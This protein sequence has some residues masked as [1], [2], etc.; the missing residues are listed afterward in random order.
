MRDGRRSIG[1]GPLW[2]PLP[3]AAVLALFPTL[4]GFGTAAEPNVLPAQPH[5]SILTSASIAPITVGPAFLQPAWTWQLLPE[6]LLYKSYLAGPH[7]P[8]LRSSWLYEKNDGWIW[9]LAVGGRVGILRLG[10]NDVYHPQGWQ[11]DIEGAAFPR[12]NME[13][14]GDLDATDFRFGIPL[15]WQDGPF[16]MKLAYYH[17]K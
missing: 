7:E 6:G 11:L 16:Q 3:I 15:T 10:T 1:A 12:L 14:Q 4:C 9:D 13:E 17:L 8:Q 5:G 2:N